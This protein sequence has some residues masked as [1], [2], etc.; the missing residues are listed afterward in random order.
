MSAFR[1]PI[2]EISLSSILK[3]IMIRNKIFDINFY[4][5]KK[6]ARVFKY[7]ESERKSNVIDQCI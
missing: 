3:P 4:V 6:D 1:L 7:K 5:H 2:T